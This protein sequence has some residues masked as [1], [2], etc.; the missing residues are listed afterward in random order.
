MVRIDMNLEL[1]GSTQ[2]GETR[3]QVFDLVLIIEKYGLKESF[4]SSRYSPGS[5]R[6][7]EYNS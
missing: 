5:G 6:L 2:I 7:Q 1:W 3:H 4:S